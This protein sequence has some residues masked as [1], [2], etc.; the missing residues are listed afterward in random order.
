MLENINKEEI[1]E[2]IIKEI[3]ILKLK[4]EKLE[5]RV[6]SL[7]KEN[8]IKKQIIKKE[9]DLDCKEKM[10]DFEGRI[11][12]LEKLYFG[13]NLRNIKT[14]KVHKTQINYITSFPL[15]GNII[16]VS[17][18]LSINIYNKNLEYIQ[19]I[20][21]AHSRN[22][23]FIDI[24]DENN[25]ISCSFDKTIKTWIKKEN[26]FQLNH[27]INNA[28][29]NFIY[30][31]IYALN[32]NLISCSADKTIKIWSYYNNNYQCI[33]IL[34]HLDEVKSFLLLEDKKILITSG[35]DKTIFWNINNYNILFIEENA[36]CSSVNALKRID[37]DKIIVGGES[38]GLIQIISIKEKEIVNKIENGFECWGI[39]IIKDKD[40]ILIGG[41]SNIIKI[42]S[43]DN[44]NCIKIIKD[45]H[46]LINFHNTGFGSYIYGFL[47]LKDGMILSYSNADTVKFWI[48]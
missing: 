38:N 8:N 30:K 17:N 36:R 2:K 15:S 44:Y 4:N 7:E 16:S 35:W 13:S 43:C 45:A 34:N 25:F 10:N 9:E 31:V 33:T 42:Y 40:V 29:K 37:N 46:G 6:E 12:T 28:H 1:I 47:E 20:K 41:R 5:E 24:K 14:K 3:Q 26:I 19:T 27:T 39:C 11:K 21:N 48:F 18:D 23:T 22:I 32:N